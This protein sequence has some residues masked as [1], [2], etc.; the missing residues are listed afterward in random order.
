MILLAIV[1][2]ISQWLIALKTIQLSTLRLVRVYAML[3]RP[4]VLLINHTL[5]KANASANA[6]NLKQTVPHHNIQT[7]TQKIADVCAIQL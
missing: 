2:V 3:V 5:M 4:I 7:S 6:I 1:S